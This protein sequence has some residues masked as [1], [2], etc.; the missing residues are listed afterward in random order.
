MADLAEGRVTKL[1][2]NK[3]VAGKFIVPPSLRELVF[4]FHQ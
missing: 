3:Y 2:Y 4:T 1:K